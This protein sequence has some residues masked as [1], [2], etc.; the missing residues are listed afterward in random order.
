MKPDFNLNDLPKKHPFQV[1]ENYFEQLPNRVMQQTAYRQKTG[2]SRSWQ[3]QPVWRMALA[4]LVVLLIF[5]GVFRLSQTP[6]EAPSATALL[7]QVNDRELV[8]YLL[9]SERVQVT[10]LLETK[11]AETVQPHEFLQVQ[12]E[13]VEEEIDP[14]VVEDYLL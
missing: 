1:P 11:A 3:Q 4:S 12:P 6:A 2:S 9:T 10:D 7:A 14:Y 13:D 5:V 8:N